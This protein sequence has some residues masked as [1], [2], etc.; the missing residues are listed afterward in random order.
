[1]LAKDRPSDPVD[2]SPCRCRLQRIVRQGLLGQGNKPLPPKILALMKAKGMQ[3]TP[4]HA[5]IFRKRAGR[6]L[7]AEDQRRYDLIAQ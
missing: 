7:E 1:M 5:R 4:H 6:D 3:R 2:R